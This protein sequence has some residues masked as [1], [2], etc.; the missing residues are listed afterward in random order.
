MEAGEILAAI[1][2]APRTSRSAAIDQVR[3]LVEFR[4]IPKSASSDIAEKLISLATAEHDPSLRFD[5]LDTLNGL[6]SQYLGLNASWPRI[7]FLLENSE[8]GD[9]IESCL[10]ILG[11]SRDKRFATVVARYRDSADEALRSAAGFAMK[12]LFWDEQ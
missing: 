4:R 2:N 7:E 11:N 1:E 6:S 3:D 5:I 12:E 9:E 10:Y 8:R